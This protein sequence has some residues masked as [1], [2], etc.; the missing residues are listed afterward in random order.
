MSRTIKAILPPKRPGTKTTLI[1]EDGTTKKILP[2][3]AADRGLF[4]GMEL[5]DQEF[6]AL[7]KANAAASA[8]AR[9]VRI[10]AASAVSKGD[11]ERRLT[12]KGE[13]PE[14]AKNAVRWLENLEL[15]DDAETARQVV[16]R[17]VARGYGAERIK[18]MLYARHI[19]REYWD[20]ALQNIPDQSDVLRNF[21][22]KR[23]GED[24]DEKTK[25]SACAAALRRGFTWA[26]VSQALSQLKE[27]EDIHESCEYS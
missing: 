12:Q 19:P 5:S 2:Q 9:A 27:G 1:L 13:D 20:E 23:L 7:E 3:V 18:Q 8:K 16:A 22:Q 14:D 4:P 24:P 25:K 26:E 11:L 17:G 6:A 15:L 10:I 21:L